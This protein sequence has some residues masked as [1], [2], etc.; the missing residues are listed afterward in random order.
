[1]IPS[2]LRLDKYFFS[3]IHVDIQEET[4]TGAGRGELTTKCNFMWHKDDP[5]RWI[6][7]LDVVQSKGAEKGGPDYNIDI[8]IAGFFTVEK[9]Y[10]QDKASQMVRANGPAL[11]YGAVREMVTLLTSRGPFDPV[12]LPSVTFVDE[13]RSATDNPSASKPKP[14][15]RAPTRKSK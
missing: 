8:Q 13:S 11:L 10:P 1:M 14:R 4:P 5:A 7:V 9:E 6:V 3:K 15:K 12:Q 2:P